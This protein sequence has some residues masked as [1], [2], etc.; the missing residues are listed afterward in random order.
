VTL[1]EKKAVKSHEK[2]QK[3]DDLK[4]E[5][6]AASANSFYRQTLAPDTVRFFRGNA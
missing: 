4:K 1:T 6:D 3:N 5:G 2:Q